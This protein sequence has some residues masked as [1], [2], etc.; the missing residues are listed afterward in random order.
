[1]GTSGKLLTAASFYPTNTNCCRHRSRPTTPRL[2]RKAKQLV[3]VVGDTSVR[4]G[5]SASLYARMRTSIA[6]V[7][8][9]DCWWVINEGRNASRN[10]IRGTSITEGMLFRLKTQRTVSDAGL[11]FW[12]IPR[13]SEAWAAKAYLVVRRCR[14]SRR[15]TKVG[16][17]PQ[18]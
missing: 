14:T 4:H 11:N 17:C 9:S 10:T 15:A 16:A 18:P 8:E 1:M 6:H 13:R 5:L 7:F 2:L 12:C 3:G